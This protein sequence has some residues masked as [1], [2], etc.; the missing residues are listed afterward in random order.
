MSY[1][2]SGLLA[3]HLLLAGSLA[4][5][6][7]LMPR[8]AGTSLVDD[9]DKVLLGT[10]V[11]H[12]VATLVMYSVG[13]MRNTREPLWRRMAHGTAGLV[14]GAMCFHGAAVLYGA[15]LLTNARQTHL[16]SLLMAALVTAPTACVLGLDAK[17]WRR[18]YARCSPS[19]ASELA[20]CIPAHGAVVGSWVG[21]WPIPLDWDRPWQLW[22]IPCV[23][24]AVGGYAL[25]LVAAQ[26]CAARRARKER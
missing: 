15:P 25:A 23:V 1:S 21:A 9:P 16:W 2:P 14:L 7:W 13:P 18:L 22:P 11:V 12:T 5:G 6:V 17:A 20:L 4:T 3:Q 8:K 26:V 24:G 19:D 10:M